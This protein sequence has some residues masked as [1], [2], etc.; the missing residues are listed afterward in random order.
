LK[1]NIHV[2]SYLAH[3][4]LEWGMFQ[5]NVVVKIKKIYCIFINSFPKIVPV[6]R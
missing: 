1:A 3:L 2:W 6:V 5:K 4:F